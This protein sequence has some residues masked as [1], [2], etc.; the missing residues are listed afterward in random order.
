MALT[1]STAT[2]DDTLDAAAYAVEVVVTF[3]S[4]NKKTWPDERTETLTVE[5][6]L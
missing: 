1:T 2:L 6:S 4:G 3:G 5:A